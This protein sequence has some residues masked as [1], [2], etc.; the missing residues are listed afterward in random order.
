[1]TSSLRYQRDQPFKHPADIDPGA[2]LVGHPLTISC[3]AGVNIKP[4]ELFMRLILDGCRRNAALILPSL[5]N[6]SEIDTGVAKIHYSDREDPLVCVA[7][8]C[9]MVWIDCGLKKQPGYW[10]CRK[11]RGHAPGPNG[12]HRQLCGVSGVV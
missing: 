11:G 6:S 9:L 2:S 8:L 1:M 5:E 3:F 12:E 7:G 4:Y 10:P